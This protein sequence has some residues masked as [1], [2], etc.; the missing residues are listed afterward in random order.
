MNLKQSEYFSPSQESK[1]NSL[2]VPVP[3]GIEAQEMTTVFLIG[4]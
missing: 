1:Q 2:F 4:S 3:N